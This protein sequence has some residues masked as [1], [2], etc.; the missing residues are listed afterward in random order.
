[1]PPDVPL[2]YAE[3]V[4][5]R[6]QAKGQRDITGAMANSRMSPTP[7]DRLID[8]NWVAVPTPDSD[9]NQIVVPE[10]LGHPCPPAAQ[11]RWAM[12][13]VAP[14][15]DPWRVRVSVS[16]AATYTIAVIAAALAPKASIVMTPDGRSPAPLW[17]PKEN[18]R[19]EF[20]LRDQDRQ[21][22]P[23]A[24]RLWTPDHVERTR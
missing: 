5:E 22:T 12:Q 21:A 19:I 13:Y 16:C 15:P 1:M 24:P 4:I 2:T 6:A 9:K 14:F 18:H 10:F 20:D 17:Y 23:S 3:Q 7:R 11:F 8:P